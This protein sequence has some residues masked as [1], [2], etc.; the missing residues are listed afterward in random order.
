M[1]MLA[2]SFYYL[3]GGVQVVDLAPVIC[4]LADGVEKLRMVKRFGENSLP[5][6]EIARAVLDNVIEQE[7]RPGTMTTAELERWAAENPWAVVIMED[8]DSFRDLIAAGEREFTEQK[9]GHLFAPTENPKHAYVLGAVRGEHCLMYTSMF[10]PEEPDALYSAPYLIFDSALL[11]GRARLVFFTK[12]S[13]E[14]PITYKERL[15]LVRATSVM[16][17]GRRSGRSAAAA[18]GRS[19]AD[20]PATETME[21]PVFTPEGRILKMQGPRLSGAGC[22]IRASNIR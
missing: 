22:G 5:I 7:I 16:V 19:A 1:V 13:R 8:P 3:T 9:H 21:L 10:E 15:R 4:G 20:A 11:V 17:G 14:A 12:R 18:G 6:G 2:Q